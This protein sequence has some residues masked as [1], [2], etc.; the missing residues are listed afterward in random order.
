MSQKQPWT[1]EQLAHLRARFPH[2]NTTQLAIEMGRGYGSVCQQAYRL[3][4]KKTE[5]F[6]ADQGLSG[7]L[8]GQRGATSRFTPGHSTWNKGM[9]GSTGYHANTQRTQFKPGQMP[10][11]WLPLGSLRI[12]P[13]GVL[14]RKVSETKGAPHLRWQPVHRLVWE[15]AHGP[16]PKGH[17]VIFKPGQRTNV[18]DEITLDRLECISRSENMKR[19]TVHTKYPPELARLVQLRG[20]LVRAI[21]E[22][23]ET[24][25][26]TPTT[27]ATPEGQP[28][29]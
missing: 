19:N 1:E 28:T 9:K 11:N 14:E 5:A 2:V 4:L 17:V 15:A 13:D 3:G 10:R 23:E 6:F 16:V 26:S 27:P 7:R 24:A 18:L 12:V 21:R 22:R 20:Q 29:P 8:V 25:P